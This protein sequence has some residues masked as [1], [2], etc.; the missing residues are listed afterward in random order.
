MKAKST[1]LAGQRDDMSW[2]D[3]T[4][5]QKI[6]DL[7][8]SCHFYYCGHSLVTSLP[9]TS[10]LACHTQVSWLLF[11]F[12]LSF[13][14]NS[15]YNFNHITLY[16]WYLQICAECSILVSDGL[17]CLLFLNGYPSMYCSSLLNFGNLMGTGALDF[18]VSYGVL[19]IYFLFIL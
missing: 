8:F 16:K 18:T 15:L 5:A 13:P 14:R 17:Q 1:V 2:G 9:T 10:A 3:S 4:H 11:L 7:F 19:A 12:S 6:W